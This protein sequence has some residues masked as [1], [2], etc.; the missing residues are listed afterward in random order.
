MKNQTIYTVENQSTN[1]TFYFSTLECATIK[2]KDLEGAVIYK[3]ILDDNTKEHLSLHYI[4]ITEIDNVI[5][6]QY[7][8]RV[9]GAILFTHPSL[10]L[11]ASQMDFPVYE[12]GSKVV[13]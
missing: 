7:I 5:M 2:A 12:N 4:G 6:F 3:V 10:S 1:E 8:R 11:V 13:L 9:D